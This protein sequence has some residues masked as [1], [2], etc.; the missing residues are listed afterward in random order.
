VVDNLEVTGSGISHLDM[1]KFPVDNADISV[2]CGGSAVVNVDGIL[3]VDLSGGSQVTYVGNATLG[4]IDLSGGS[5]VKQ[6]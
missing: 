4:D 3:D 2:R 5:E 6:K 1:G